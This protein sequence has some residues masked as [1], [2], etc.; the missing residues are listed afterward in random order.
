[1]VESD[2]G[3]DSIALELSNEVLVVVN[4]GLVDHSIS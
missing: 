4:T 3:S 1:M 2:E